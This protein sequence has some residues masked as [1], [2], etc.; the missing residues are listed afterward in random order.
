MTRRAHNLDSRRVPAAVG[1]GPES[2][3]FSLLDEGVMTADEVVGKLRAV[4]R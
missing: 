2:A 3:L 4:K 1:A